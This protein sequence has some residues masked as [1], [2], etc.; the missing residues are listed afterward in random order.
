MDIKKVYN[1]S[2]NARLRVNLTEE[3]VKYVKGLDRFL[4]NLQKNKPEIYEEYQ[5]ALQNKLLSLITKPAADLET[6]GIPNLQVVIRGYNKHQKLYFSYALHLLKIPKDYSSETVDLLWLQFLRASLYPI[7]YRALV[8][9]DILER[10]TGI[11]FLKNY[12]VKTQYEQTQPNLKLEDVNHYWE[13]DIREKENPAP[14]DII[15][16]R[17]H[18]GKIGARVDRCRLHEVMKPLKDPELSHLL[19]CYGDYAGVQAENPN[20]VLTRTTTLMQGGSYCDNCL[21]DKRHVSEIK[22]PSQKFYQDLDSKSE[23]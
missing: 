17:F 8:L 12:I 16:F 22:H 2:E 18:K 14:Q 6:I 19:Y 5:E 10:K 13:D 20:F 7:Y 3:L 23:N 21:H 1:Y 11:K 4:E 9:C 15:A